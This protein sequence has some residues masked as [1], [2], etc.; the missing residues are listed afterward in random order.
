MVP[1]SLYLQVKEDNAYSYVAGQDWDHYN[2]EQQASIISESQSGFHIVWLPPTLALRDPNRP[3]TRRWD[4]AQVLPLQ[5]CLLSSSLSH[6]SFAPE[7]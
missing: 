2:L 7:P 6:R 5:P 3:S 4:A 1:R